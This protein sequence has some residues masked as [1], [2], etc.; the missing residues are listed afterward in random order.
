MSSEC[1][2]SGSVRCKEGT[3]A[4]RLK[5]SHERQFPDASDPPPPQRH[6]YYA[7]FCSTGE[8][9]LW[10]K[11]STCGQILLVSVPEKI[12]SMPLLLEK[13]RKSKIRSYYVNYVASSNDEQPHT[14]CGKEKWHTS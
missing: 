14:R 6:A 7:T 9:F 3:R 13:Q 5:R 1:K 11:A 8:S 2:R 12:C 10:R 4:R